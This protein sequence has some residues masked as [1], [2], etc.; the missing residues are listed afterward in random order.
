MDLCCL[1]DAAAIDLCVSYV[2]W[3]CAIL[4]MRWIAVVAL[5]AIEMDATEL[6]WSVVMVEMQGTNLKLEC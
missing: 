2:C 1:S 3:L 5:Q 6:V 4:L